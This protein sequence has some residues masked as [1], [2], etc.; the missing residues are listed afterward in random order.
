MVESRGGF[1]LA[2][3]ARQGIRA[4]ELSLVDDLDRDPPLH[5]PVFGEVNRSHSSAAQFSGDAK[6]GVIGQLP[7]KVGNYVSHRQSRFGGIGS[8]AP[9]GFG[10]RARLGKVETRVLRAWSESDSPWSLLA[11]R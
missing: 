9:D 3:K 7:W 2:Q 5:E 4:V 8:P 10:R 6:S 1:N 11:A